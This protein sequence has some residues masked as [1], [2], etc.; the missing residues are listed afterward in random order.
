MTCTNK[1]LSKGILTGLFEKSNKKIN[2]IIGKV[3]IPRNFVFPIIAD[4]NNVIDIIKA[5]RF[6]A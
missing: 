6:K 5:T 1:K 2:E 3:T 4:I